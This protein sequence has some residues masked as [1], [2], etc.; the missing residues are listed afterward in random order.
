MSGKKSKQ[1]RMQ[2]IKEGI[3][4][5]I[6]TVIGGVEVKYEMKG[7]PPVYARINNKGARWEKQKLFVLIDFKGECAMTHIDAAERMH[8]QLLYLCD[9]CDSLKKKKSSWRRLVVKVYDAWWKMGT[10]IPSHSKPSMLT[11]QRFAEWKEAFEKRKEKSHTKNLFDDNPSPSRKRPR[12]SPVPLSPSVHSNSF[13]L[14]SKCPEMLLPAAFAASSPLFLPVSENPDESLAPSSLLL[15]DDFTNFPWPQPSHSGKK[16]RRISLEELL[17][18]FE[19]QES[20]SCSPRFSSP[21]A[22]GDVSFAVGCFVQ[23]R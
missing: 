14:E 18:S 1:L 13:P 5:V 11:Q 12:M 3:T 16:I 19:A 2:R 15:C 21:S 17:G 23:R 20:V 8:Q 7:K 22:L 6:K 10:I 9:D 4:E